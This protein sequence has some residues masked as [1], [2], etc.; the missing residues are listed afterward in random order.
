MYLQ[1]E[2]HE[3]P[4]VLSR[5]IT[6]GRAH[7]ANI[8]QH[9]RDYNPQYVVIAA[10]GTSDNA[11]RYAQYVFGAVTGL[12]VGLSTPSLHTLY[13]QPPNLGRALVIGI[14]QSG[15]SDDVRQVLADAHQHGALTVGITNDPSSPIAQTAH[16]HIH[17]MAGEEQSVAATKTYTA[18]L[19]AIASLVTEI[20]NHAQMRA[21][22]DALPHL[23]RQ[24]LAQSEPIAIWAE[25]Y[26]YM[27][28]FAV[29]GRGYNYATAFEI[30]LKV[31][32]LCSLTGEGYS[33]ADF[34]HGPIAI[35]N[36]DVPIIIIAPDGVPFANMLDL[37]TQLKARGTEM[38]VISNLQQA[39]DFGT[40]IM[41]I[42]AMPEWMTP[43]VAVIPGQ[44]FAMHQALVR[45]LPV[46]RPHGLSKVTVTR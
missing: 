25:R 26:R 45:G 3:Q 29:I 30:S 33:E 5:L 35:T 39:L 23:V 37:M 19:C 28:Q 1:S 14:S 18:Q 31:K 42:P 22:L 20:A 11:A 24:T 17:L 7:I 13:A 43:L 15:K 10:R 9:I 38:M 34:R 46:D 2:I 8:A 44:I 36:R 12:Y 4:A 32:E 41:P 21:Q 27:T 6:D 16:H 40:K